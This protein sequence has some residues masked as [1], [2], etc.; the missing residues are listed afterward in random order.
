MVIK[1]KGPTRL[2]ISGGQDLADWRSNLKRMVPGAKYT[3]QFKA[4]AWDGYWYPGSTARWNGNEY[5]LSCGRGYLSRLVSSFPEAQIDWSGNESPAELDIA[6]PEEMY[7]HQEEALQLASRYLW[8]RFALATNAG[9]GAVIALIANAVA[10][11]GRRAI[12]LSDEV[13]V[14]D[15]LK[16]EFEKW[17][18]NL[19][20]GSVEAG[21]KDP[22]DEMAVVAMIPT[23]YRRLDKPEWLEWLGQ[24]DTALLDEADKATAKTWKKTLSRLN[25]TTR[26]YGFSGTFPD[27]DSLDDLMLEEL[28]GPPLA[29]VKNIDLVEIEVSAKPTVVLHPR[30]NI[31]PE[32]HWQTWKG[33]SGPQRR[34]YVYQ[35]AILENEDRHLFVKSLIDPKVSNAVIVNRIAH[36]E[37]LEE[38]LPDS[39]FIDG[40]TSKKNRRK[41][42][43]QFEAG[44]F[45]T[46]IVTKIL[47]RGSNRL[48]TVQN[49]IFASGEGS[50]RQTLQRIGRG[51]RRGDGKEEITIQDIVDSGHHY[52]EKKAA[53]RI[54]LYNEE[55]FD[56]KVEKR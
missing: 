18:P 11:A 21:Q 14:V 54:E 53:E 56:I 35:Q 55:G 37:A 31:I 20:F 2:Y 7:E 8:G 29:T 30:Q 16:G 24:I 4:R 10:R 38:H 22:P 34:N 26:R 46:L 17:A 51:L 13:A 25:S 39:V 28:M 48:G 15:A 41:T 50:N 52:L 36:G 32:M 33:L 42:L 6:I 23:L 43:D 5:S 47:D 49:I 45:T 19:T 1:F 12:I 27:Q 40:S 44:E 9:K 3:P